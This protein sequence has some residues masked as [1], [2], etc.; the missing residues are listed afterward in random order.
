MLTKN[1]I[2]I[3]FQKDFNLDDAY[4]FVT[5]LGYTE[6]CVDS[7]Q[8]LIQLRSLYQYAFKGYELSQIVLGVLEEVEQSILSEL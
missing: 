3:L 5:H 4:A 2:E 7:I 6:D 1:Q 8:N